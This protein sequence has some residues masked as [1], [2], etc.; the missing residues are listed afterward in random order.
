MQDE[1]FPEIED[2][3]ENSHCDELRVKLDSIKELG[4]VAVT[5]KPY[6]MS[7]PSKLIQFNLVFTQKPHMY[8]I[9]L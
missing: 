4:S 7:I 2:N 9:S 6:L 5:Q 1:N 8:V 3:D